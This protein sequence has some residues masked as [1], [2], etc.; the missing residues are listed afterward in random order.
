MI[1][2][3]FPTDPIKSVD[4]TDCTVLE[5]EVKMDHFGP[6]EKRLCEKNH[7][8]GLCVVPHCEL[9]VVVVVGEPDYVLC[10]IVSFRKLIQWAIQRQ[11]WPNSPLIARKLPHSLLQLACHSN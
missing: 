7:V 11:N 1:L 8:L 3:R 6:G 4:I 2:V 9:E 10:H 5:F